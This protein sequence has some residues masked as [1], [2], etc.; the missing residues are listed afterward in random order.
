MTPSH[1]HL[2]F[3][4][5]KILDVFPR[6]ITLEGAVMAGREFIMR[7]CLFLL[8]F[9]ICLPG[10]NVF[11][12]EG[13]STLSKGFSRKVEKAV[14]DFQLQQY[15]DTK[16]VRL[17]NKQDQDCDPTDPTGCIDVVCGYLGRSDCDDDYELREVAKACRGNRNGD[18]IAKACERLGR[19]DCDDEYEIFPIAEACRGNYSGGCVD[20]ACGYLGRSSCDDDYE[21]KPII[22]GCRNLDGG[23]CI[24][25]VC[26]RLG[27]SDC[28]DDYEIKE[29][30]RLCSGS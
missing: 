24:T 19:S 3:L 21:L 7:K 28:D 23:S 27:R 30:L 5:K 16:A 15:L 1:W 4:R 10:P 6:P 12:K 13:N 26:T 2:D 8:F 9:V 22:E 20:T 29:V 18:C 11:S 17:F 25:S 14:S